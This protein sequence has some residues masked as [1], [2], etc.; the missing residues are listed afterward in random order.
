MAR[1]L[2]VLVVLAGCSTAS[3]DAVQ[4]VVDSGW[5]QTTDTADGRGPDLQDTGASCPALAVVV[6]PASPG[7]ADTLIAAVTGTTSASLTW[8]LIEPTGQRT[9][10]AHGT[11]LSPSKTQKGQVFEVVAS[12]G[13]P[14]CADVKTTVT[15]KNTVPVLSHVTLLPSAATVGQTLSCLVPDGAWVDPDDGDPR[16]PVITWTVNAVPLPNAKS[17][18]LSSGFAPH[19]SVTCRVTPSDGTSLGA[20]VESASVAI[21]DSPPVATFVS[22]PCPAP[23]EPLRCTAT[24]TD[25]DGEVPQFRFSWRS[26]PGTCDTAAPFAA[27]GPPKSGTVGDVLAVVPPK[28]TSVFCCATPI[29]SE[30]VSG[31]AM[32]SLPCL[33]PNQTP[34]VGGS[35]VTALGGGAVTRLATLSCAAPVSDPDGDALSTACAWFI[36]GAV[37]IGNGC[38][39]TEAHTKGDTVCCTVSANDGSASATSDAK[40]CVTVADLPPTVDS[41]VIAPS[42]GDHCAPF[43]C[44]AK[45]SDADGEAVAVATSWTINGLPAATINAPQPDDVIGCTATPTAAGVA[46][47]TV[48]ADVVVVTNA[49]PSLGGVTLVGQPAPATSASQLSCAAEGFLDEDG[50]DVPGQAYAWYRNGA[51]LPAATGPTLATGSV[52]KGDVVV[53]V[54]TPSDGLAFGS[55]IQSNVLSIA[56]TP[57]VATAVSVVPPVGNQVTTFTCVAEATDADGDTL[58]WSTVWRLNGQVIPGAI[59]NTLTQVAFE[60]DGALLRCEATPHDAEGA[61]QGKASANAALLADAPPKVTAVLVAPDAPDTTDDLVC[62]ATASDPEGD[63]TALTYTW[64]RLEAQGGLVPIAGATGPVLPAEATGHHDVVVCRATPNDGKLAGPS[65]S[66]APV[67]VLNTPPSLTKA[68]L[69]PSGGTPSNTF[70]CAPQGLTDLDA[71]VVTTT[72]TWTVNG[73]VLPGIGTSELVPEAHAVGVGATIACRI[74]PADPES[75]GATVA[76]NPVVLTDCALGESGTPCNDQNA[77]TTTDV[78]TAGACLGASVSCDDQNPCTADT[79]ATATGCASTPAPATCNDGDVCT[80]GDTCQTGKCTGSPTSCDDQNP[81]TTDTCQTGTGCVHWAAVGVCDDGNACTVSD[82]CTAGA[83]QGG[84]PR[85]CGDGVACTVD[86]CVPATGC[87]HVA[88]TGPCE[89]GNPCTVNDSCA[90]GACIGGGGASCEDGTPCTL[91]GC[92]PKSGCTHTPKD[93]GACTDKN[94]CTVND[95]CKGG[96]CVGDGQPTCDDQNPC[97][98]DECTPGSGCGH[99]AVSGACSGGTCVGG[100]CCLP[101]CTGKKCGPDAC[102][103]SCGTCS[104]LEECAV[105]SGQC[106]GA[107]TPGM[108]LVPS[109]SFNM[110]CNAPLDTQCAADE[111]PY[112]LVTLPAYEIDLREVTNGAYAQC[113][114]A[115]ACTAPSGAVG[116]CLYG[117]GKYVDHPVNCVDWGQASAFCTWQGK[118]LCTEAEWEKAARGTDGR[119]W[120]WGNVTATCAYA[121]M[122]EGIKPGCGLG[123]TWPVGLIDD[124]VSPYGVYDLAGNVR[125]WVSDWYSAT[126]Y[127]IS[128]AS[129]PKGPGFG[130]SKLLRGGDLDRLSSELRTSRRTSLLPQNSGPSIGVR[131]CKTY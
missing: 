84:V 48:E 55:P 117:D 45:A 4:P 127:G 2:A 99:V 22:L 28:G 21:L 17:D 68:L 69:T 50:C 83:C 36:D 65:M 77:C 46:G 75:I 122:L 43:A 105:A 110:G 76:S 7:T 63:P 15:I 70:T 93:G 38:T 73:Q 111:S 87:T 14:G 19:D 31:A 126:Y 10:V 71:D 57:P 101:S 34:V 112:H 47:K 12:P 124:G 61:G 72:V 51:L 102:G 16:V 40:T 109:G 98:K 1:L 125:E 62:S 33:V 96:V 52:Q 107:K 97:T 60:S 8:L 74:T 54:A 90:G 118:R 129:A 24:G 58:T 86:D 120:P 5:A 115:A 6:E 85:D 116:G 82:A 79:C 25:P 130:Q 100:V 104:A 49:A 89:D 108:G 59:G 131:C 81:C 30:G 32:G 67:T 20:P 35:A 11:V 42:T 113:V 29:D 114:A 26:G 94:D 3:E 23:G 95:A 106:E 80:T 64:L 44:L 18:T 27:A 121:V 13:L 78:C 37:V 53:C 88:G 39:L 9:E 92:D 119:L 128:P 91:D 41:V 123:T 66:S 103:G 56:N